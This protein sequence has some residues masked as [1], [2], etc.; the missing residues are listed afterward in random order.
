MVD[1][2]WG[3]HIAPPPPHSLTPCSK[4]VT[5]TR[6]GVQKSSCGKPTMS[7]SL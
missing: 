2:M 4:D 3:T 1:T 6:K 5:Y 7:R